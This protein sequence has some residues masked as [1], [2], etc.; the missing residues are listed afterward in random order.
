MFFFLKAF[1]KLQCCLLLLL[2]WKIIQYYTNFFWK[3]FIAHYYS[4]DNYFKFQKP[5]LRVT[6]PSLFLGIGIALVGVIFTYPAVKYFMKKLSKEVAKDLASI[7]IIKAEK[8]SKNI[9]KDVATKLAEHLPHRAWN[10]LHLY[11]YVPIWIKTIFSNIIEI[12][13]PARSLPII[14]GKKC[15]LDHCAQLTYNI[16]T[17]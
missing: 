5:E 12:F 4:Y 13:N 16:P 6:D 15:F 2:I 14:W 7:L 9:V 3:K 1:L 11:T 17:F 10:K 8:H